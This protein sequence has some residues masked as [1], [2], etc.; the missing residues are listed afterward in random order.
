MR[1]KGVITPFAFTEV[2][3]GESYDIFKKPPG[4]SMTWVCA[5]T[6]L[7]EARLRIQELSQMSPAEYY[8]CDLGAKEVLAVMTPDLPELHT[9]HVQ[10]ESE[11]RAPET[12]EDETLRALVR[13]VSACRSLDC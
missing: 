11:G 8:V 12:E 13:A 6:S 5:V 7:Q 3:G 1:S 9:F 2:E 10:Q 4:S